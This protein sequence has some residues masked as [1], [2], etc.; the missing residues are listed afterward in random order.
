FGVVFRELPA[1]RRGIEPEDFPITLESVQVALASATVSPGPTCTPSEA[2]GAI[3]APVEIYAGAEIPTG[4][5]TSLPSD[6]PWPGEEL[7]W[8][9]D[10]P[11]ALSPA[12]AGGGG[13]YELSFNELVVRD[14]EEMPI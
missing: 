1:P 10:A 13:R 4:A 3:V 6:G 7:V 9:A 11:L 5:I 12:Q 2:G 14:E 8:A